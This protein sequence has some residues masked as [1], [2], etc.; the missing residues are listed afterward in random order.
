MIGFLLIHKISCGYEKENN[1]A[2]SQYDLGN[3]LIVTL[4]GE[5]DKIS[6]ICFYPKD[7][8][9]FAVCNESGRLFKIRISDR[10]FISIWKLS[11]SGNFQ[12]LVL[13]D[14][15]FYVLS[16]RGSVLKFTFQKNNLTRQEFRFPSPDTNGYKSM[17]FDDK[18]PVLK[19][20]CYDKSHENKGLKLS[21][22]SIDIL[23][24]KISD[25]LFPPV[26]TAGLAD[27]GLSA[28]RPSAAA[29]NPL[30]K[31][32]FILSSA[33]KMLVVADRDGGV[34]KCFHLSPAVY[35]KPEG[36]CFTPRGDMIISNESVSIDP[37]DLLIFKIRNSQQ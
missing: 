27:S 22:F 9:I 34:K 7:T 16:K 11:E 6:G 12:D 18:S 21:G 29:I 35:S 14:S 37:A 2:G 30:T 5:L 17:F 33:N 10:V 20:L 19:V 24:E 13:R 32:L 8:A 26:K 4:P 36:I 1:D 23:S 25:S 31:E 15:N 28:F 3:P